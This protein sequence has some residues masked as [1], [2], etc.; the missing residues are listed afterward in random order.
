M[1]FLAKFSGVGTAL[2]PQAMEEMNK[3]NATFTIASLLNYI[4]VNVFC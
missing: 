4:F 1:E 2:L 3:K